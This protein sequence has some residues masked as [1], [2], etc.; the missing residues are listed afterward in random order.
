MLI[1][2][3]QEE[4]EN[5]DGNQCFPVFQPFPGEAKYGTVSGVRIRAQVGTAS[6]F[7]IS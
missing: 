4:Q 3:Q 6:R 2:Q 1:S 7:S 5:R